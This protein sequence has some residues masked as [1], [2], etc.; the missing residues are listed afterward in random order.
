MSFAVNLHALPAD[1]TLPIGSMDSL[2]VGLQSV[3]VCA[4][5]ADNSERPAVMTQAACML[6]DIMKVYEGMLVVEVGKS[7]KV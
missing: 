4:A 2:S 3:E 7:R 6:L 5:T 1:G